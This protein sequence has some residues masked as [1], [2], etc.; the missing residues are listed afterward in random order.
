MSGRVCVR[1]PAELSRYIGRLRGPQGE[2][3]SPR[4]MVEI[5][6]DDLRIADRRPGSWEGAK[7]RQL[8][9]GHGIGETDLDE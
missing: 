9:E 5:L 7:M 4:D 3:Y 1:V 8:L 2:R 6:V